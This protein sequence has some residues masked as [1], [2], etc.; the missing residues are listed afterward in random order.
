MH[1]CLLVK[2]F[3]VGKKFSKDGMPTKSGAEFHAENHAKQLILRGNS[4][5]IMAKKRYFFTKAREC[6]EGIDLVR[7]HAPFRWLEIIIRLLTTHRDI[8][9]Y[10][11]IG[12]PSFAVWAILFA[13]LTGKP[14]TLSL[15][16][17]AELFHREENWR[18]RIFAKCDRYIAL[19]KEIQKGYSEYG[20]IDAEKVSVLPQG[21]DMKK[22]AMPSPEEKAKMREGHGL[23]AGDRVVVFCSRIVEDKGIGT[24]IKA[25]PLVHEKHP[26]AKF[27]V[28]GGG[29]KELLR[30]LNDMAVRTDGSAVIVGE[31]DAP[32][33][34]YSLGDIYMFPSRH[35]G[36]PT[37]LIEA[38]SSGLVPVTSA[39]GGC[40][41]VIRNGETGYMVPVDDAPAFAERLNYLIE[42]EEDCDRMKW[43]GYR[44]MQEYCDYSQV[45]GKLEQLIG[46]G[47]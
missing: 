17:K 14:V 37:S 40:E 27:F 29:K 6:L 34:Y 45:I 16:G 25:W 22:F 33:E 11:I 32:Q 24:M 28:V 2:D 13:K 1:I 9:A 26:D 42:H 44:L 36:F 10:Y 31:V 18:C 39:I 19:S 21:L 12:R 4:V 47:K 41:D 46:K 30:A 5:T 38:M 43:N 15:T 23:G 20:K 3:A 7:L 8:D 35:E